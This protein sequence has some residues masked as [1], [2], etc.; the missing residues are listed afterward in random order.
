MA[1]DIDKSAQMLLNAVHETIQ[2]AG[3][4][5]IPS[6]HLYMLL[7]S[8]FPTLTLNT[9]NLII[10]ILIAEKKITEKSHLLKAI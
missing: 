7:M 10:G 6:G 9:Y 4:S 5:G 2:D 8:V 3:K 1:T